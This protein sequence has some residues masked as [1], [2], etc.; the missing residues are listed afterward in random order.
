MSTMQ[1]SV[2]L[3]AGLHA[4]VIAFAWFGLPH[5][6]NDPPVL[7]DIVFVRMA[8]LSDVTNVPPDQP[9]PTTQKTVPDPTPGQTRRKPPPKPTAP[10]LTVPDAASSPP[11]K[12]KPVVKKAP[13]PKPKPVVKTTPAP[14]PKPAAEPAPQP[15]PTPK[16]VAALSKPEPQPEPETAPKQVVPNKQKLARLLKNL[17]KTPPQTAE[18]PLKDQTK[19]LLT[20]VREATRNRTD[21]KF[22]ADRKM[23]VDEIQVVRQQIARC[24]NIAAGARAAATLNVEI[25][26]SVNPDATIRDATVVN[27]TRMRTDPHFRAAAESAL[28]ALNDPQCRRLLLP[29]DKYALW[30]TFIFNFDPRKM[31]Q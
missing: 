12:P 3:S 23:T 9:S 7:D 20:R 31:L 24:W 29:P 2:A 4:I 1:T 21:R 17:K 5:L 30:K 11:E 25:E 8:D 26:M 27:Q 15:K 28:R 13:P 22:D 10:I 18:K 6:W 14:K 16:T 19:D